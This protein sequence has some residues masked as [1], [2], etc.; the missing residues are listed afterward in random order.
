MHIFVP[1]VEI[2]LKPNSCQAITISPSCLFYI[3]ITFPLY[4]FT[5]VANWPAQLKDSLAHQNQK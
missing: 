4:L 1:E 3:L 5:H 2:K